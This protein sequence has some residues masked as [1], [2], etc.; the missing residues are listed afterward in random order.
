MVPRENCV[1]IEAQGESSW[2]SNKITRKHAT[3]ELI[4]LDQIAI[5]DAA[6]HVRR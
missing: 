3:A 1:Q 2:V 5:N 4:Q 6:V